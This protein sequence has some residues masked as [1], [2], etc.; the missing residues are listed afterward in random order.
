MSVY[1]YGL[2]DFQSIAAGAAVLAS[3]GGGSYHDARSILQ[4]LAQRGW[5]GAVRVQDYDGATNGCVL[6]IMGSP[7]AA[8]HLTLADVENS[9][10]NTVQL[11]E[12]ST[13]ELLGC[14][15]PV[16]IGP[17]NS[18]VPLIGASM[19]RGSVWVVNGDGAGRAVPQ[20][21]QT[22]FTG[23]ARL[24]P[25]PCALA[26]D[27][28]EPA[29]VESALLRAST[30][31]KV[32]TLAG[33][34]VGGF[35]G[36]SGIALWP[37][38]AANGFAMG[39]HYIPGT[40]EQARAVGQYLLVATTPPPTAELASV[41]SRVTGRVSSAVATNC[42]VTEVKQTTS[43]ASLDCGTIR[44]DN[45]A[46]PSQSTQTHYLYNLNENLIMYSSSSAAPVVMAPDSICYY[47]EATGRGFSNA[48]DDLA[49]YFDMAT[50]KSTGKTVSVIQVQTADKLFSTPGVVASFAALLRNMGYAGAMPPA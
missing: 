50:G 28:S 12:N 49:E 17:I 8:D 3:G 40:L 30:A 43:S 48:G 7:D 37:F 46:D 1:T 15:V 24:A 34:V 41:I 2:Q 29:A 5:S 14:F 45:A 38:N 20:L 11:M 47:S 36:Y 10:R 21:P 42:Y 13:G 33:G 23:S 44:L 35:G 27:A 19:S 26:S 22:T 4:E 25:S 39:G 31:A 18:L 9:I 32:E 6:A 16:E